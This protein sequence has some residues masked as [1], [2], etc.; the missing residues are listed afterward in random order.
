[1]NSPAVFVSDV[2]YIHAEPEGISHQISDV[3]DAYEHAL[4]G[5]FP[6]GRYVVGVRAKYV[7]LP[8]QALPEWLS[9]WVFSLNKRPTPA[10]LRK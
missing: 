10:V 4:C 7:M 3:V 2:E 8:L 9:D 5:R 1:M 6:R